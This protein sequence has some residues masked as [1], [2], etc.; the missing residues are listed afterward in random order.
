M[1]FPMIVGK[2]VGGITAIVVAKILFARKKNKLE[3]K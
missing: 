2:L 1:I 3:A